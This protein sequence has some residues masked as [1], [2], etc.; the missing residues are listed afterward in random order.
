MGNSEALLV[1]AVL[2]H[3]LPLLLAYESGLVVPGHA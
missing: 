3:S 1:E 2:G